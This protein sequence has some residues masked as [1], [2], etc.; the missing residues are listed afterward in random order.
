MLPDDFGQLFGPG[1]MLD[2]FFQRRLA[3][4][5]DTSTTPWTYKPLADGKRPA[6]PAALAEFQRAA[7]IREVFF[8]GGGKTPGI[9][10][11]HPRRRAG[12]SGRRS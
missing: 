3:P 6:S 9:Q 10:A 8:R 2:D 1:G 12:R 4:L 7:R 5:V 11:R